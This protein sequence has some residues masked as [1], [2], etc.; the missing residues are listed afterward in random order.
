LKVQLK[1]GPHRVDA[2]VH[3]ID[4]AHEQYWRR[5]AL[6]DAGAILRAR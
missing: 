3:V 6:E 1:D 2:L 5:L 4:A